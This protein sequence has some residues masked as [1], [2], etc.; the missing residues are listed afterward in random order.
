MPITPHRSKVLCLPVIRGFYDRAMTRRVKAGMRQACAALDVDAIFPA[1]DACTEGLICRDRGVRAYW[2]T[3]RGDL[4]DIKAL[5]AFSSDFMDERSVMDTVRLLPEDVPIFL[6]VNNDSVSA[7]VE[8]ESV[9]DGLCGSLSVHH[10]LRMIGRSMTRSCRI[11]MNDAG[12]LQAKLAECLRVSDG[13]EALRH[14]RIAL[15]GV[16]PTPFAT[17]FSNQMELF[18]LGFSLHTYELL[19]M[20]GDVMLGGQLDAGTNEYEA[21]FGKV[22]LARP[23]RKDDPR[24]A[25]AKARIAAAVPHLPGDEKAFDVIARCFVWVEETFERDAIDAGA[26][27]C[28]PEFARFF[29]VAPCAFSMFANLL[30]DKPVVCEVDVCHAIMAKLGNVMS[31]EASVILDV[32]NNGWDPRVFNVFHCSQT[33]ANWLVGGGEVTDRGEVAGVIQAAPFTAVSAATSCDAF[34]AIVFTGQFLAE[35]PGRRGSSGWAFVPNNQDVLKAIEQVG[36]HHF[37]A[38]KGLLPHDVADALRFKGLVVNDLSCPVP[39]LEEIA[40]ELPKLDAITC[41][42][43]AV[44]SE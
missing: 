23:V 15:L 29:G 41:A 12:T 38:M 2:E 30:L 19:D 20:W 18:R 1:D 17:T 9:G 27:H 5:I 4:A 32:N 26:V 34:H 10:N 11:D 42:T 14:M 22:K 21:P 31:G 13:I 43:P 24:V 35:N 8:G 25:Q 39:S 6:I 28:W 37:V 16:N 3:W 33:P 36:I 44:Y 40:A 7:Q